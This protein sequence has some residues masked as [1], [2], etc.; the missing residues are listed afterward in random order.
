[1]GNLPTHSPVQRICGVVG[2]S[3]VKTDERTDMPFGIW[4]LG[5]GSFPVR[6]R[7][8]TLRIWRAWEREPVWG[9]G[10]GA[11]S[12]VQGQSPWSGGKGGRS[13]PE[14]EGILLPK[15]ANLSL[16]FK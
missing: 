16:S 10:G 9:S 1:M 11:P 13:P 8:G 15:R 7:T 5:Q 12:G 6:K 3:P 2:V 14:A 4:T